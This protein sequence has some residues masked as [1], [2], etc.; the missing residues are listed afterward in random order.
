M[1]TSAV[2]RGSVRSGPRSSSRATG[3]PS[4]P[5]AS[6]HRSHAA[7]D[8]GIVRFTWSLVRSHVPS[9]SRSSSTPRTPLAITERA[10]AWVPAPARSGSPWLW[11][12]RRSL[13]AA[14]G[15]VAGGPW[16]ASGFS[17]RAAPGRRSIAI[18][19]GAERRRPRRCSLSDA[20]PRST[21]PLGPPPAA[22][23]QP[24]RPYAD[25]GGAL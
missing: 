20:A 25:I 14:A 5:A 4:L 12:G 2:S 1:T 6:R 24:R 22:A 7:A 9:S 8:A 10:G 23:G 19:R 3:C 15:P 18:P 16:A 17:E 21:C 13:G 11:S